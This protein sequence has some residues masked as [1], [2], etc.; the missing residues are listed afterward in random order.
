MQGGLFCPLSTQTLSVDEV[1]KSEHDFSYSAVI[2]LH[3][4]N[5]SKQPPISLF[6]L[7]T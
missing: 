7:Q 2:L 4:F 5:S 3:C 6:L 1:G